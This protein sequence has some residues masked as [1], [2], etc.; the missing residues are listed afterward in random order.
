M[1]PIIQESGVGMRVNIDEAGGDVHTG[2]VDGS[3]TVARRLGNV[4]DSRD[5]IITNSNIDLYR[6]RS[7][8]IDNGS[9]SDNYIE[10]QDSAPLN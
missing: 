2:C 4:T 8:S 9:T 6:W 3:S 5:S 10:P 1:L 7:G